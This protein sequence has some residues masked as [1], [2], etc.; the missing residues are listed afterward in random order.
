M[1]ARLGGLVALSLLVSACAT[2]ALESALEPTPPPLLIEG[3][4]IRNQLPYTIADVMIEAPAT[5]AFAGCGNIIPR[6]DCSTSFPETDYQG[7]AVLIRWREHGEAKQLPEFGIEVPDDLEPG[8]PA[9]VEVV[10]FAPGQAGAR[11]IQP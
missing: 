5:G 11:L 10:V 4:V 9:W 7:N 1:I 3:V 8:V 2:D 6:T